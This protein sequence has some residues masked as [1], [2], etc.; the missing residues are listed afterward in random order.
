MR[1]AARV[2]RR[3]RSSGGLGLDCCGRL[4]LGACVVGCNEAWRQRAFPFDAMRRAARVARRQR[5][6][7]RRRRCVSGRLGLD[8][9]RSRTLAWRL[10]RRRCC[11]APFRRWRCYVRRRDGAGG[12]SSTSRLL[13]R[14][15]SR[16]SVFLLFTLHRLHL[17]CARAWEIDDA[18]AVIAHCVVVRACCLLSSAKRPSPEACAHPQP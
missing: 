7:G 3:R 15:V 13:S 11:G 4:R 6:S 17:V 5:C 8:A 9:R 12:A 18:T 1:R 2:A 14:S 16:Q 10:R